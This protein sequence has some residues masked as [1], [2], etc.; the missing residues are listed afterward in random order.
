MDKV[1]YMGI[2]GS[3]SEVAA[4]ELVGMAGMP[5]AKLIP[6]VCSKNILDALE[7]GEID[8]GVLGVTNTTAGPVSEF[9]KA[10]SDVDYE[11]LGD[12]V[13]PIHH[14]VFIRPEASEEEITRISSHPQAFR[15]TDA[16][17][18]NRWP[19]WIEVED[20]DTALAAEHLAKGEW[21]PDTAVICSRRAGDLWGLKC[22]G[23]NIED[24]TDNRTTFR[25]LR[26][27][28]KP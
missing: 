28:I 24:R 10:F 26:L 13:L 2:V 9:E 8:Y 4:G 27:K 15:Q 20:E 23:E 14:C 19:D 3:F 12:F 5:D 25:L 1:G 22:I 21:P 11:S 7:A 16:Y 17:R 6:M 18:A